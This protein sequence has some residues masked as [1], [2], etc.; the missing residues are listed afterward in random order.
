MGHNFKYYLRLKKYFKINQIGA[1]NTL[2]GYY[3]T[4]NNDKAFPQIFPKF[5]ALCNNELRYYIMIVPEARV[6]KSLGLKHI[7]I[8][9]Y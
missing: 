8:Y 7:S 1:I 5:R 3:I 2:N 4:L 6:I 9:T